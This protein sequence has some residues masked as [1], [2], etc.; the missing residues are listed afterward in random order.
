MW[1]P[2]IEIDQ[3]Y[4]DTNRS[5]EGEEGGRRRVRQSLAFITT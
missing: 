1:S 3:L 2:G 4:D 5:R